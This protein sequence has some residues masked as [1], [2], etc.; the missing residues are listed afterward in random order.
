[1]ESMLEKFP[2]KTNEQEE[3]LLNADGSQV[4]DDQGQL[5][6]KTT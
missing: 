5:V 2:P 3:P 4:V 1:M 6:F